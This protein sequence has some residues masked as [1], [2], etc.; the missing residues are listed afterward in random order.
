MVSRGCDVRFD[1]G[2]LQ[3]VKYGWKS[4]TSLEYASL[5]FLQQLRKQ[6]VFSCHV[7][8]LDINNMEERIMIMECLIGSRNRILHLGFSVS[9]FPIPILDL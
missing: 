9:Q 7:I 6:I 2:G 4:T 5:N 3:L 1:K 8:I